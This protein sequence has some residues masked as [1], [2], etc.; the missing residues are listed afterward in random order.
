MTTDNRSR[1]VVGLF[2][3]IGAL[4]LIFMIFA[5]YTIGSLK[6]TAKNSENF[7]NSKDAQI[8]V[9]EVEGVI[10]DSKD[11]IR[12]LHIAE[13]ES[14]YKAIILRVNSPGGAVGPTQEIYEEIK[15]ID[16]VKPVYASFGT[17]AASGG[18]YIGAA[19]RRIYAPKGVMTGSIGVIMNFM[20]LSKVYDW[21]RVKPETIKSGKYKDIGS[22]AREMRDY[23]RALLTEMTES[24]H[25]QFIDDIFEIR[26]D[27]VVGGL[28]GLKEYSQGQ[29]FSGEQAFKL[30]LVDKISSLW[31]AG[32][33]IHQELEIKGDFKL[34][35]I[36]LKKE[37]N[38]IKSLGAMEESLQNLKSLIGTKAPL[39]MMK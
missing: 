28:D 19:C 32:R 18:Y 7:F 30:G 35:F 23:E 4:F 14:Q 34:K 27:K 16:Q 33:E 25:Q 21:A 5:F 11:T 24:V 12:K 6:N 36:E 37:F 20:D 2:I 38:L 39:Y 22:P 8:A 15:R 9:V 13:N 3:L 17:V 10:M 31:Q 26:K 29:I 1:G